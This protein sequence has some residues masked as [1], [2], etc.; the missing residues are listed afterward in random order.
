MVDYADLEIMAN[1]CL[2]GAGLAADLDG[3]GSVDLTDYAVLADY[4]LE[5]TLWP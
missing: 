5:E 4:C 3:D 1:E 2:A